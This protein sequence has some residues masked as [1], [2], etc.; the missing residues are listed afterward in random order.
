M[1]GRH[2]HRSS[3]A[4][5]RGLLREDT[6]LTASTETLTWTSGD[7][8]GR[9]P[10]R[11]RIIRK[12]GLWCDLKGDKLSQTEVNQEPE[13]LILTDQNLIR[14]PL[15]LWPGPDSSSSSS[16]FSRSGSVLAG[17]AFLGCADDEEQIKAAAGFSTDPDLLGPGSGSGL[18]QG[19]SFSEQ[20][21]REA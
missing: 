6:P 10:S 7:F 3:P 9:S 12:E 18:C 15:S 11:G 2:F 5:D 1:F 8:R 21:Q 20:Q 17:S 13:P 16:S 19:V 14:T 4:Y